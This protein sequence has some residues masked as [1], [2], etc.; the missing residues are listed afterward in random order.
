MLIHGWKIE[1]AIASGADIN[2]PMP[3]YKFY[4]HSEESSEYQE[5][6][7]KYDVREKDVSDMS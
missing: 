4:E 1:E 3:F 7:G 5:D 6:A 2:L